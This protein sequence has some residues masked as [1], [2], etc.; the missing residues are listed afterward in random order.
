MT[1]NIDSIKLK[2]IEEITSI[3]SAEEL[4]QIV[5]YL[6]RKHSLHSTL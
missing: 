3:N 5:R 1:K 2:L 4:D 6:N